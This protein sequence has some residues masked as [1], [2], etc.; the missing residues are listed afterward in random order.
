MFEKQVINGTDGK[1]LTPADKCDHGVYRPKGE[2]F[3][4]YCT[5]CRADKDIEKEGCKIQ[6]FKTV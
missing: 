5:V 3:A 6:F 1:T 2:A 4:P